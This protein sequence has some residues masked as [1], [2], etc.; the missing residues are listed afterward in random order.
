M[1]PQV[2]ELCMQEA[3]SELQQSCA[4]RDSWDVIELAS[5]Q[6]KSKAKRAELALDL[7]QSECKLQTY[8]DARESHVADRKRLDDM[9]ATVKVSYVLNELY[10][11]WSAVV[12]NIFGPNGMSGS[13]N[14]LT[15]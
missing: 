2:M 5:L 3:E 4:R 7:E 15:L 8:R 11:I 14:S 13:A 12:I 10:K 9:Q 6:A 1:L